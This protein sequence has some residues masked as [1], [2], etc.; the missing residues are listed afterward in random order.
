LINIPHKDEPALTP[1]SGRAMVQIVGDHGR[2]I[3]SRF[4]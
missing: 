1:M 4:S 2:P 3:A